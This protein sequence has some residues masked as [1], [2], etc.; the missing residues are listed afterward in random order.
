[1]ASVLVAIV[2]SHTLSA[3]AWPK[4]PPATSPALAPVTPPPAELKLA[5]F[6]RKYL[7]AGGMPVVSSDKVSDYALREAAFVVERLLEHRPDVRAAMIRNGSRVT[8]MAWNEF[9]TDVPEHSR[10]KPAEFWNKRARGLGGTRHCP[11]TSGG[12]ENLLNF[13]GDPYK[14]ENIFIHE[15]AHSM[16]NLGLEEADKTFRQRLDKAY[17]AARAAGKWTNTYAGESLGEYWAEGVQ[18]WFD[19]NRS[20]DRIHNGVD[21]REKLIAYD[22]PLA[23]LLAEV[24]GKD[25][26]RYR[27]VADRPAEQRRHLA[28]YDPARSPRF[29]WPDTHKETHRER[30]Q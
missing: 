23:E 29:A 13:V 15:F 6:Y 16:Q 1:M 24:F 30:Q 5:P 21:T 8:V 27:K 20:R 9:T 12:E 2:L 18:S 7:S 10:L 11:V 26:W 19:T 14:T 22:P 3:D 4:T 28:G 25:A 17:Q